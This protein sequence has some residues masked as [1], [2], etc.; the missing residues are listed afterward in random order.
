MRTVIDRPP[1]PV[2]H[3]TATEAKVDLGALTPEGLPK[4]VTPEEIAALAAAAAQIQGKIA[5]TKIAEA[6]PADIHPVEPPA[7]EH[8][9]EQPAIS[10][11]PIAPGPAPEQT[12]PEA[13]TATQAQEQPGSEAHAAIV[14][15][16]VVHSDEQVAKERESAQE[17]PAWTPGETAQPVASLAAPSPADVM[18]AI[19]SLETAGAPI[20]P[21]TVS[22]N[23]FS[24]EGSAPQLEAEPAN[25][26]GGRESR[27]GYAIALDRGFNGVGARK[28][29][30][31][32]RTKCGRHL[33]PRLSSRCLESKPWRLYRS[34]SPSLQNLPQR[35]KFRCQLSPSIKLQSQNLECCRLAE[36]RRV[37]LLM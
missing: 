21:T 24:A 11:N 7:A 29:G 9:P 3:A 15:S 20:A 16:A 8:L 1:A 22:G 36:Q 35:R 27:A 23:G 30:S 28:L 25:H 13:A 18:A 19:S 26:G 2:V 31:I 14:A 32:L 5:E 17:T 34:P 4:D 33:L 12:K 6:K 37:Q 10:A